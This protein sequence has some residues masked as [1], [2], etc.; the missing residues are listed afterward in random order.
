MKGWVRYGGSWWL[1]VRVSVCLCVGVFVCLSV[2]VSVCQCDSICL[3]FCLSVHLSVCQSR[4]LSL[5]L[6]LSL[7]SSIGFPSDPGGVFSYLWDNS[8]C[9]CTYACKFAREQAL[10]PTRER[11]SR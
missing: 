6:A 10:E 7:T 1:A 2:C 11:A 8:R 9:V 3:S 4:T 5:P